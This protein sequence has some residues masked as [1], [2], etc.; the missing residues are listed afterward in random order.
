MPRPC[1][2]VDSATS[3][4]AHSPKDSSGSSTMKVSLS[5]PRS[6][7]SPSAAPSSRPGLS[8]SAPA[9]LH[10]LGRGGEHGADVVAGDRGRDEPEV[11]QHGVAPADVR[12]VLE[13]APEAVLGAELRERRARVGDGDVVRAVALQRV[14][15]L[16]L[17]HRLDRA[18]GLRGDDEQR[19]VEVERRRAT[20]RIWSGCVESSTCRRIAPVAERAAAAPRARGSSRPCRAARRR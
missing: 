7:S 4:S 10:R 3:C 15:V 11:G 19:L 18:A 9:G 13:H 8:C 16:E 1:L 12:V 2:P 5:R 17:R 6:A 20:A 14:E